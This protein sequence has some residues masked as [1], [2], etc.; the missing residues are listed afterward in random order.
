[1]RETNLLIIGAGPFGLALAAQAA[2]AGTEHLVAGKPME[3]WRRNMPKG[4]YLRSASDWHL[5]PINLHTIEAFLQSQGKTT[6]DVEPLSLDFYLSYAEWFQQEKN[7]RP[8]PVYIRQLDYDA[9]TKEFVAIT[10][11]EQ[12]QTAGAGAGGDTIRAQNVVLAPGFKHFMHVSDDLQ[13]RLPPG[14]FQHTAEF[15][16]FSTARN[17]RYLIIGGRQSAFEWAAL[18]LESGASAV[19][20]SHR[21]PSPAFAESD[22]SWVNPLVDG[23]VEDPSWFRR[24]TDDEKDAIAQRMWAEGRLK[25]EPWLEPRL[26]DERVKFWP[27]TEVSSCSQT[28]DGGLIAELSNGET[29]GCD[30]IVLATGYKVDIAKLP[31]LASGN[32]LEQLETRNGF[33]VL[34]DHFETTVPRLFITSLPATQDFGPFFGFTIAVRASAKLICERLMSGA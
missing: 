3:F 8:L 23:I 4:M 5:D 27:H 19:H 24:L 2:H 7:I 20:L 10:Q 17:R 18:L 1:M 9:I 28:S 14:R 11:Q 13:R 34:D 29:V 25:V 30:Q 21:H 6:G 16:D 31:F 12:E 33:P 15:V 22:W 32:I 26:R